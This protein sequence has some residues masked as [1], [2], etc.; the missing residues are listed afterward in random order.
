MRTDGMVAYVAAE[1]R[2]SA[3]TG[4]RRASHAGASARSGAIHDVTPSMVDEDKKVHVTSMPLSVQELLA[5]QAGGPP[6]VR[7]A[8]DAAAVRVEEGARS[9]PCSRKAGGSGC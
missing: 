8:T 5:Q 1:M 7:C 3:A 6:K 4:V 2:G 9:T